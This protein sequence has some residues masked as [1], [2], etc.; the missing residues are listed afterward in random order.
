LDGVEERRKAEG[1]LH[2]IKKREGMSMEDGEV[3]SIYQHEIV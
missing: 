3:L 2:L 1:M